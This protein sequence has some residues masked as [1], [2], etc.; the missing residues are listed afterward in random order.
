[1]DRETRMKPFFSVDKENRID[2]NASMCRLL[3]GWAAM[4]LF[5]CVEGC[6][7]VPKLSL[8]ARSQRPPPSMSPEQ[9]TFVAEAKPGI[10]RAQL[11]KHFYLNASM[12]GESQQPYAL[13][14]TDIKIKVDFRPKDM[15]LDVY[16]DPNRRQKWKLEHQLNFIWRPDDIVVTVGEPY[17]EAPDTSID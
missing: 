12:F 11:E 4:V 1:M 9:Q 3:T 17:R 13:Y 14:G 10:T 8:P 2:F 15:P 6:S 16:N 5:V 7:T